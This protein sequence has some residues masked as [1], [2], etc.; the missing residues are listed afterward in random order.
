MDELMKGRTEGWTGGTNAR[1][2]LMDVL[3]RQMV[4]RTEWMDWTEGLNGWTDRQVE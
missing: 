2:G 3:E 4:E 1:T